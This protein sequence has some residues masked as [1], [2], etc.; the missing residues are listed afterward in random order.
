MAQNALFAAVLLLASVAFVSSNDLIKCA[1]VLCK[2][3]DIRKFVGTKE[4]IW[5][6]NTT[7]K[8]HISCEV[9]QMK[10]MTQGSI[11]FTRKF[12]TYRELPPITKN[13]EGIF[14]KEQQDVMQLRKPGYHFVAKETL[15]YLSE[16][17]RCAVIKVTPVLR[18][19]LSYYDLR[20]WNSAVG[21]G[22]HEKCITRFVKLARTG[23][24]IYNS[25]CQGIL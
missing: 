7:T 23:H 1:P 8:E 6:S 17:Y 22:P 12:D 13:H 3:L 10:S 21:K 15:V 16:K 25:K 9:D 20:I 2:K 19:H 14:P 18:G 24:I 4:P 11:L 5:T